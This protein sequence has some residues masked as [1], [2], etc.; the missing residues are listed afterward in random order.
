MKKLVFGVLSALVIKAAILCPAWADS[1]QRADHLSGSKQ[2]EFGYVQDIASSN[3]TLTVKGAAA[4]QYISLYAIT[5]SMD[6]DDYFYITCGG[7]QKTARKWI[8][9]NGGLSQVF[10]PLYIQ[11]G[12][13]QA[14]AVV[15]GAAATKIGVDYWLRQ[16]P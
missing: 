2:V 15:R 1:P 11:C 4:G 3:A 6:A 13:N 14:L 10:F 16:E 5:V 9:A 12:S 7:T 8:A